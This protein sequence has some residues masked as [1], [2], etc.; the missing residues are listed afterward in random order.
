MIR[1]K[2]F[3]FPIPNSLLE[4]VERFSDD[5]II[6]LMMNIAYSIHLLFSSS[7]RSITFSMLCTFFSDAMQLLLID[8]KIV[9]YSTLSSAF[10]ILNDVLI[11]LLQTTYL[12][13]KRELLEIYAVFRNT[14]LSTH[15]LVKRT[16]VHL[17]YVR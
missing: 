15:K 3:L 17:T 5:L 16:I 8:F 1:S 6:V 12:L 11:S 10:W 4:I 7:G 2:T 9:V 14:H 13:R